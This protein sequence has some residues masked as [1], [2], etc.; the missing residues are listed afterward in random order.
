MSG[1]ACRAALRQA[2]EQLGSWRAAGACA[3][4][5]AAPRR[6]P[7]ARQ[8]LSKGRGVEGVHLHDKPAPDPGRAQSFHSGERWWGQCEPWT[9]HTVGTAP[10]IAERGARP[11]GVLAGCKPALQCDGSPPKPERAV[12]AGVGQGSQ[13]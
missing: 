8:Y 3:A 6:L 13:V 11:L 9:L 5:A 7:R 1:Q 12:V 2:T 10:G 4:A